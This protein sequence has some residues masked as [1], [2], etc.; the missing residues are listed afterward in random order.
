M[1]AWY[2]SR[3]LRS[4][5]R[6]VPSRFWLRDKQ[7]WR[8]QKCYLR[9]L[10]W[11]AESQNAY[12]EPYFLLSWNSSSDQ[13]REQGGKRGSTKRFTWSWLISV[14][15]LNPIIGP[16]KMVFRAIVGVR[17]VL[18]KMLRR[19][20]E[21]RRGVAWRGVA[22]VCRHGEQ[23]A[24]AYRR[25]KFRGPNPLAFVPRAIRNGVELLCPWFLFAWSNACPSGQSVFPIRRRTRCATIFAH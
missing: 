16:Q 11:V 12:K 2:H 3:T 19:V 23:L 1:E 25:S 22:T 7:V 17:L 6:K 15:P 20:K 21:E 13:Q 4:W 9:P 18:C 14:Q 8:T 24:A 5:V 10:D